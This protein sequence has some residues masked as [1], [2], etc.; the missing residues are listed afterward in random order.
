MI[1]YRKNFR[2]YLI[3]KKKNLRHKHVY[4]KPFFVGLIVKEFER[5][6]KPLLERFVRNYEIGKFQTKNYPEKKRK[7]LIK[8]LSGKIE[9]RLFYCKKHKTFHRYRFQG[10]PSKTYQKCLDSDNF[11]K[12]KE[13]I[14]N[15]ELFKLDF[16][17]VW[18][19]EKNRQK[20]GVYI[21]NDL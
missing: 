16:K 5:E 7:P 12:F 8:K 19:R 4:L 21:T 9:K 6:I 20:K 10:K 11:Y 17:R 1:N 15:Y 14:E 18:K 13:N 2:K 3:E